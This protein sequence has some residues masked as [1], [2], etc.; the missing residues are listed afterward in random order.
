MKTNTHFWS[1]LTHFF[2]EWKM[3]QTKFV[4]KLKTHILY[5]IPP[6]FFKLCRS[7]DNVE[8]YGTA[9]QATDY[10]II[11]RLRFAC[12]ITKA[13]DTHSEYVL[14]IVTIKMV[15]RTRF[16]VTLMRTLC[17][18]LFLIFYLL[19]SCHR[20]KNNEQFIWIDF[21]SHLWLLVCTCVRVYMNTYS[22]V[23]APV[24]R[25]DSALACL[26]NL[27]I[28]RAETHHRHRLSLSPFL[29]ERSEICHDFFLPDTFLSIFH[30]SAFH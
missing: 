8:K 4:E 19:P 27:R 11:W 3:F 15:T 2:L 9:G 12:W 21:Y 18:V 7:W 29:Q 24:L 10:N 16:D 5:W 28:W 25:Q 14:L 22:S 1:Y 23:F 20:Q 13:T 26:K 6:L 30:V 17:L